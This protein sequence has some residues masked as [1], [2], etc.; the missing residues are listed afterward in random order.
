MPEYDPRMRYTSSVL[1]CVPLLL[2]V[3][4]ML[5]PVAHAQAPS[6]FVGTFAKPDGT[7]IIYLKPVPSGFHGAMQTQIGWFALDAKQAG[8]QISGTIYNQAASIP[9]SAT[10]AEGGLRVAYNGEADASI[11][12]R[13]SFDHQLGD[14]DITPYLTREPTAGT[15]PPGDAPPDSDYSYSQ[16][17]PGHAG[18]QRNTNPSAR[19][20]APGSVTHSDPQLFQAIAGSRLVYYTR[21]SI[22]NDSTASSITYVSFC[23]DNRFFIQY[24][25][26]F[27]VEGDTGGNAQGA[28]YGNKSGIWQ[29]I[30]QQGAPAVKL[31]F[32]NGEVSVNPI[33]LQHLQAGRWRV[34]NTQYAIERGKAVCY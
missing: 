24:D 31:A 15:P 27:S 12:T 20:P 30:H 28:G 19:R 34:G 6:P 7:V 1:P 13:V 14:V 32:A 11:Y 8:S 33:N 29:I 22:L 17:M 25:S 3:L 5:L 23:P 21:T 2:F 9:W 26:S 16:S 4:A 10:P 18:E